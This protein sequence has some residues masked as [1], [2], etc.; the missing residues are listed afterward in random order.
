M[1]INYQGFIDVLM[2]LQASSEHTKMQQE[3]GDSVTD[4]A[5]NENHQK[6]RQAD[7]DPK[8][9]RAG[10]SFPMTGAQL[11]DLQDKVSRC[12]LLNSSAT[13]KSPR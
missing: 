5:M 13:P 9:E 1:C 4:R 2:L 11:F 12:K 7:R 10:G 8:G 6:S 3:D